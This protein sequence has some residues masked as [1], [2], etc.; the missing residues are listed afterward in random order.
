MCCGIHFIVASEMFYYLLNRALCQNFHNIFSFHL[1]PHWFNME[2]KDGCEA[3]VHGIQA[4]LDVHLDRVVLSGGC[5]KRLQ[6][7]LV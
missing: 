2:V 5:S 6:H 7:H 3:M 4:A 1:S